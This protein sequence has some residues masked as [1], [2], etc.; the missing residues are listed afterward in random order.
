LKFNDSLIFDHSFVSEITLHVRSR[1]VSVSFSSC[2][3]DIIHDLLASA[4]IFNDDDSVVSL[5]LKHELS[6]TLSI[7]NINEKS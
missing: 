6:I 7:K 5:M 1:S 2:E 4:A 3:A